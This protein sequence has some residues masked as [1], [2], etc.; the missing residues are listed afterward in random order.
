MWNTLFYLVCFCGEQIQVNDK[1][2]I[3]HEINF[4]RPLSPGLASLSSL[5]W[6]SWPRSKFWLG[7]W[8]T[9]WVFNV[10]EQVGNMGDKPRAFGRLKYKYLPAPLHLKDMLSSA[11]FSLEIKSHLQ[12][13]FPNDVYSMFPLRQ[14]TLLIQEYPCPWRTVSWTKCHL[15]LRWQV[16]DRQ[17]GQPRLPLLWKQLYFLAAMTHLSL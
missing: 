7:Y 15:G 16:Q 3:W 2:S 14:C 8:E 5:I 17:Y 11:S 4:E 13:F 9:S 12:Y 6:K 1:S 10:V